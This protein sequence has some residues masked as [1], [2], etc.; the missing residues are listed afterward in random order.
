M[1]IWKTIILIAIAII[2]AISS[3]LV[4]FSGLG[5]IVDK[6]FADRTLYNDLRKKYLKEAKEEK[7]LATIFLPIFI[8]TTII[9]Y[10]LMAKWSV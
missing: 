6:D 5:Y 3:G 2:M 7:K 4:F 8:I 10:W 9:G 1:E